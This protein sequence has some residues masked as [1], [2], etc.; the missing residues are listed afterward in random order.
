MDVRLREI[1]DRRGISQ[2]RL[3]AMLGVKVSRYGSWERGD[4]ML[5]LEQ[6]YKCAVALGCTIDEIAGYTPKADSVLRR[7]SDRYESMNERGRRQLADAAENAASNPV[8]RKSGMDGK[9]R[10]AV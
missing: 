2:E 5:S 6:A 9:K 8:N 1:R 4:R 3:A 10:R 7:I